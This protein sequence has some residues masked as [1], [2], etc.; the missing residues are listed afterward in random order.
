MHLNGAPFFVTY[1][2]IARTKYLTA[3][4][5]KN[6]LID[7]VDRSNKTIYLAKLNFNDQ[8]HRYMYAAVYLVLNGE[9]VNVSFLAGMVTGL[10]VKGTPT[11]YVCVPI[12]QLLAESITKLLEKE[13]YRDVFLKSK[14]SYKWV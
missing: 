5:A 1:A 3:D 6:R 2:S 13:L 4:E 7:M 14:L 10:K 8:K 11:N 12:G 9:P